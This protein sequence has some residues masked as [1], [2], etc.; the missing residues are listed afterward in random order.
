MSDQ[1]SDGTMPCPVP[2][3]DGGLI[4]PCRKRIPKG[5]TAEEGHG[6]GHMW[7]SAETEAVLDC[8]HYDATALL[9]GLPASTHAPED[10]GPPCPCYFDTKEAAA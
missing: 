4:K 8:G 10:C 1:L 9:A 2:H 7:M 6:G 5:W 3:P